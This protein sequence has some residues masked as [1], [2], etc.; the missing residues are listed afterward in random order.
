MQGLAVSRDSARVVSTRCTRQVAKSLSPMAHI[1]PLSRLHTASLLH[2]QRPQAL[3]SARPLRPRARSNSQE[4]LRCARR[5]APSSRMRASC[6]CAARA[7]GPLPCESATGARQ[8]RRSVQRSRRSMPITW[9]RSSNK[10]LRDSA[11]GMWCTNACV[12]LRVLKC[13]PHPPRPHAHRPQPGQMS[14][15]ERQATPGFFEARAFAAVG[16]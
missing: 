16:G 7:G 10:S 12:T 14:C 13:L 5:C 2:K 4:S 11:K 6:L 9:R 3:C 15:S 8:H 1:A